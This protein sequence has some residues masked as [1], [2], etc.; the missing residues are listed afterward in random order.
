[1]REIFKLNAQ[2]IVVSD[3]HP[4]GALS[5]VTD[6]PKYFDSR[7]YP[8][9]D[10]N[11]NGDRDKALRIARAA[12]HKQLAAF[13]EADTRAGWLVTLEQCSDGRQLM[14]DAF[15]G[16]PDMTPAPEPEPEPEP[17][18]PVETEGE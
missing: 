5:T 18:E 9:A 15:G 14:R 6:Y 8:A 11:P 7:N 2:Q 10:G 16:F 3:N 4:E 1:M 13:E 12:Y 17:E